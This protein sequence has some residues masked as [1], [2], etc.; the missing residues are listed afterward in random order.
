MYKQ[1][2]KFVFADKENHAISKLKNKKKKQKI[3]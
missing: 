3:K 1:K 2:N